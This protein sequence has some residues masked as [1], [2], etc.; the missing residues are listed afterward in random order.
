MG[1]KVF[2]YSFLKYFLRILYERMKISFNISTDNFY[3]SNK[4][5]YISEIK[6]L[7]FEIRY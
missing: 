7:I 5:K 1:G 2:F 3:T 6:S 4:S